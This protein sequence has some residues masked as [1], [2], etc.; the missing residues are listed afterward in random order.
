[1]EDRASSL[2]APCLVLTISF[3]RPRQ[4]PG[5]QAKD[6]GGDLDPGGDSRGGEE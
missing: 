2:V 1:M 4:K 6:N 5:D 3:R